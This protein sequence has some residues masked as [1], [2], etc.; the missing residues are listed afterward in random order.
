MGICVGHGRKSI[1][2]KG[3]PIIA[4][5]DKQKEW[6]AGP[7]SNRGSLGSL[8]AWAAPSGDPNQESFLA[9]GHE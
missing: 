9:M 6:W 5:E 7:D 2:S 8:R 3:F 1:Q 4:S